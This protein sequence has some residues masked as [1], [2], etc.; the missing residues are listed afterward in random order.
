MKGVFMQALKFFS[1]FTLI[2]IVVFQLCFVCEAN[3]GIKDKIGG[4]GSGSATS[5]NEDDSN[6]F[7]TVL[8]VVAGVAVALVAYKYFSEKA[9]EAEVSDSTEA[10]L[11]QPLRDY[12]SSFEGQVQKIQQELPVNLELGLSKALYNDQ[13]FQLGLKIKL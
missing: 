9:D 6:S 11:M 12:S 13:K 3:A 8:Y 10:V 2:L 7:T 1:K 4:G 5:S